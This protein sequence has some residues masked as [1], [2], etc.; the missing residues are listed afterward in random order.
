MMHHITCS[1]S[2]GVDSLKANVLLFSAEHG[3]VVLLL[4]LE[5]LTTAG[6]RMIIHGD[7]N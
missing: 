6:L 7:I 1:A 5:N 2:N 3:E 4:E